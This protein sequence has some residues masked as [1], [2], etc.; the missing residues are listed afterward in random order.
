MLLGHEL[1]RKVQAYLKKV[2]EGGGAVS[3]RIVTA[4]APGILLSCDKTRLEEYGGNIRLNR[5]WAHS[6]LKRMH[7][8]Q[9]R[10]TTAKSRHSSTNFSELQKSFLDDVVSTVVMEE[11]P[12]ELIMNWDQTDIKL[13][14]SSWTMEMAG[15]G[16]K[17]RITAIFCGTL[18]DFLPVQL[19]YQGKSPRCHPHYQFPSDWD[20][21]HSPKHWSTE[22]TMLQYISNIIVPYVEGTRCLLSNI[23][24]MDNFKGQITALVNALL[25]KNDIHVCLLPPNTTDVLQ[26]MDISVNDPAKD[27]LKGKFQEW[28]STQVMEQLEGQDIETSEIKNQLI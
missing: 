3:A 14:P 7:F 25:E 26:P 6:L 4:A 12:A 16:D 18:G 13:F 27:F 10:A 11:I 15:V 21:T 22:E 2:R 5:H 19:I 8:V 9:R 28:Y 20:V 24:I 17:R 23:A 1:D